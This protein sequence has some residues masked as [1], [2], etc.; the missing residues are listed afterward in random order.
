MKQTADTLFVNAIVVTMDE[1]LNQYEPGAVAVKDSKI[2]AVGLQ[3]EITAEW[4]AAETVNCE[5]RVL[6]P[7]LINAHTHV[8]MTLLRG[9]ADDLRLDVWLMGYCMPVEREFVSPDF[10]RLGTRLG[11]AEMI[12][13]GVTTYA[14]MYYFEDDI[15]ATTAE[16]GMRALLGESILMFPSPDSGSPFDAL[17]YT[18]KFIENWKDHPL[19]TPVVSPHAALYQYRRNPAIGCQTCPRI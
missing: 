5:Q 11:C 12:R 13:S 14:D 3:D 16:I 10:V 19:I 18:R 6:L 7:G 1:L 2:V 4:D 17:E 9:L 15:A 8:P